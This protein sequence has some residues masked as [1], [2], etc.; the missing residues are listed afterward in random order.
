MANLLA[1]P[2]GASWTRHQGKSSR[3]RRLEERVEIINLPLWLLGPVYQ[4]SI[5][6]RGVE[7]PEARRLAG[8]ALFSLGVSFTSAREPRRELGKDDLII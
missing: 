4:L 2:T 1:A 8:A 7:L 6:C 3:T 5:S